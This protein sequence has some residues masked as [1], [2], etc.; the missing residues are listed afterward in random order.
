MEQKP[1]YTLPRPKGQEESNKPRNRKERKAFH[2]WSAKEAK[3]IA[4]LRKKS[5]EKFKK[6]A[7][8]REAYLR[9]KEAS[10]PTGLDKK[11]EFGL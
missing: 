7:A 1:P 8:A 6:A 11:S 3:R 5:I 10:E 9:A 4:E 2:K